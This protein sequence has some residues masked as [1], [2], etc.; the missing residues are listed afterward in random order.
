MIFVFVFV[1]GCFVSYLYVTVFAILWFPAGQIGGVVDGSR[2]SSIPAA[3]SC[4]PC[5][6]TKLKRLQ[7]GRTVG[8]Y[9]AWGPHCLGVFASISRGKKL[10]DWWFDMC[11]VSVSKAIHKYKATFKRIQMGHQ[12]LRSRSFFFVSKV[13]AAADKCC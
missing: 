12:H 13:T 7:N 9:S 2:I 11:Q 3:E 6:E 1:Y 4:K 8:G 5:I 10:Q